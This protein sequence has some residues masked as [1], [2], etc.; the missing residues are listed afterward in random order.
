LQKERRERKSTRSIS[1]EY[2]ARGLDWF[3]PFGE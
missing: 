3:R 1:G 2:E